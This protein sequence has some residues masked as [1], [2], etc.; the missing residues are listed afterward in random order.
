M[1]NNIGTYQTSFKRNRICEQIKIMVAKKMKHPGTHIRL[2]LAIWVGV[3]TLSWHTFVCFVA[4]LQFP[5][6]PPNPTLHWGLGFG[7]GR[8]KANWRRKNC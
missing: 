1:I 8:K 2:I 6:L 5:T 3:F 7:S 4:F